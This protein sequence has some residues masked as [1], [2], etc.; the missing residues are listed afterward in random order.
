[1]ERGGAAAGAAGAGDKFALSTGAPEATAS[2]ATERL[3]LVAGA[4]AAHQ[5][6]RHF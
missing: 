6:H 5:H 1:M 4:T 3:P 2:G